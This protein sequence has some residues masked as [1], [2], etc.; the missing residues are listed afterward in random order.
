LRLQLLDLLHEVM[1]VVGCGRN[2]RQCNIGFLAN[3]PDDVINRNAHNPGA[4]NGLGSC[5]VA[6]TGKCVCFGVTPDLRLNGEG[7]TLPEDA[8]HRQTHGRARRG[9]REPG[10]GA[11]ERLISNAFLPLG[12]GLQMR[13]VE[14]TCGEH[15]IVA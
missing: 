9:A 15:S 6:A 12:A 2:H 1:Q 8:R 4:G 11:P 7:C 3:T 5:R 14:V 10:V 13:N